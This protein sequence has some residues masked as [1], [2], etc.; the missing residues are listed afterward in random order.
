M[1]EANY[2]KLDE[3][4]AKRFSKSGIGLLNQ[5]RDFS[6]QKGEHIILILK[7]ITKETNIFT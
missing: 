1:I 3:H 5:L 7:Y 6:L 2:Q 4:V